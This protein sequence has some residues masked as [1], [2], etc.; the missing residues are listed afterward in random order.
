MKLDELSGRIPAREEIE[1]RARLK[2]YN[3]FLNKDKCTEKVKRFCG[4]S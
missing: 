2:K 1:R 4:L 3:K